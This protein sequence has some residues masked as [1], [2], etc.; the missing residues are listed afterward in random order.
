MNHALIVKLAMD[1]KSGAFALDADDYNH[2]DTIV[3]TLNYL[4]Q[5]GSVQILIYTDEADD[6]SRQERTS[7]SLSELA[8]TLVEGMILEDEVLKFSELKELARGYYRLDITLHK[9]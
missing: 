8:T 2:A 9:K 5:V 4:R 6:G 7:R 1:G 3:D